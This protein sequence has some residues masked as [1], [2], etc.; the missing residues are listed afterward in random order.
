MRVLRQPDFY[1]GLICLLGG[2]YLA[3]L[4][5]G[6]SPRARHFPFWLSLAVAA[7]GALILATTLKR[8]SNL[9]LPTAE[10]VDAF[11]RGALP[12]GF[13]MLLW[14]VALTVDLGYTLPGIVCA[15][16]MLCVASERGPVR[17]AVLS[18]L[19]AVVCYLT[20]AVLFNVRLPELSIIDD[21]VRPVRRLIH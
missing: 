9:K 5:S 11:L 20:F 10:G 1:L 16:G 13:F 7:C 2:A 4:V 17:I 18:V 19:I 6:Y 3:L 12:F 14:V 8:A 21:L 15:A